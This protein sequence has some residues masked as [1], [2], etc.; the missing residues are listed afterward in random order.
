MPLE[1]QPPERAG[2][3]GARVFIRALDRRLDLGHLARHLAIGKRR[4]QDDLGHEIESEREIL[5][6]GRQRD[7]EVI[8]ARPG[9]EAAAHELDRRIELGPRALRGS[10]REHRAGQIGEPGPIRGV[11]DRAGPHQHTHGHDRHRGPLGDQQD[12]PVGQHLPVRERRRA[13]G[14]GQEQ[15]RQS[16][17][18][19]QRRAGRH[20]GF[21]T[22][23]PT[24]FVSGVNQA[25]ATRVRSAAVTARIFAMKDSLSANPPISS[26]RASSEA[27]WWIESSW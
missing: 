17:E 10:P 12:D 1:D 5:L 16:S 11:V 19:G 27:R 6:L 14:L 13:G 8:A 26:K 24:L 23:T 7:G 18:Q 21:G 2:C 15:A 9:L 4:R 25:R 3:D 22:S 20:H